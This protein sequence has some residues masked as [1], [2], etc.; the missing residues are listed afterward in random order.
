MRELRSPE[1]QK[2]TDR[3]LSPRDWVRIRDSSPYLGM[4]LFQI[5]KAYAHNWWVY[6]LALGLLAIRIWMRMPWWPWDSLAIAI[7]VLPL[8]L[9]PL[10]VLRG[11][12]A[13]KYW[14][15]TEARAWGRWNE[16]LTSL[17]AFRDKLPAHEMV[18][19]EAQALAGLGKLDEALNRIQELANDKQ[20]PAWMYWA[21]LAGVCATAHD[22]KASLA[23]RQKTAELAPHEQAVLLDYAMALVEHEHDPFRARQFLVE[24]KKHAIS[25]SMA[26][27]VDQCEGMI[28]LEE[29][30]AAAAC[31]HLHRALGKAKRLRYAS[32]LMGAAIDRIHT[33]LALAHAAAGERNTALDHY[34][35]A[36]PRLQALR[37]DDLIQRCEAAL[38]LAER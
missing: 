26:F 10:I 29:G 37:R 24:A 13:D 1:A 34:R 16:V 22:F 17:P 30:D 25:D 28:A 11:S 19:M 7:L 8:I 20:V 33:V 18:F 3:F 31:E 12:L 21:R 27:A 35:I 32:A 14:R 23:A 15:V 38:G 4:V 36:E 5:G 9:C 2:A 6:V